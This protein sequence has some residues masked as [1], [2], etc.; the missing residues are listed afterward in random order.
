MLSSHAGERDGSCYKSTFTSLAYYS[1]RAIQY[2]IPWIEGKET[3][4]TIPNICWFGFTNI[5]VGTLETFTIN[6][7]SCIR[8]RCPLP[9]QSS[10]RGSPL[11][12]TYTVTGFTH[13]SSKTPPSVLISPLFLLARFGMDSWTPA[14]QYL[15]YWGSSSCY[16][17]SRPSRTK[18]IRCPQK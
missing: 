13:H 4:R 11:M 16:G 12:S 14:C 9:E 1:F 8:S 10:I 6:P 5:S 2:Q 17:W 7:R 3:L 15:H 18:S